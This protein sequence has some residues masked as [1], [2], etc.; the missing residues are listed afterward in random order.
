[1]CSFK[2]DSVEG[3]EALISSPEHFQRGLGHVASRW[4]A[5]GGVELQSQC[6]Q[7]AENAS[8]PGEQ[9]PFIQSQPCPTPW[10]CL[11][12]WCIAFCYIFLGY[13]LTE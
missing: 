8:T 10:L 5:L 9:M 6:R 1:M 13:G 2:G 7:V 11:K 12:Q 4:V 3:A